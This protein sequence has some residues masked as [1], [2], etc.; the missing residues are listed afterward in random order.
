MNITC[1]PVSE[2]VRGVSGGS[3]DGGDGTERFLNKTRDDD[4]LIETFGSDAVRP[5]VIREFDGFD[6]ADDDIVDDDGDDDGDDDDDDDLLD[7]RLRTSKNLTQ[8]FDVF[9]SNRRESPSPPQSHPVLR[10]SF[11]SNLSVFGNESSRFARRNSSTAYTSKTDTIAVASTAAGIVTITGINPEAGT[12]TPTDINPAAGNITI[13]GINPATGTVIPTGINPAAG[14]VTPTGIV[15]F[16]I[17][18]AISAGRLRDISRQRLEDFTST[19]VN[20]EIRPS[21]ADIRHSPSSSATGEQEDSRSF[22]ISDDDKAEDNGTTSGRFT[23]TGDRSAATSDKLNYY[24]SSSSSKVSEELPEV[25]PEASPLRSSF[26][27]SAAGGDDEEGEHRRLLVERLGNFGKKGK[28]N[29]LEVLGTGGQGH[30]DANR[31]RDHVVVEPSSAV[32]TYV[33][34]RMTS[35]LNRIGGAEG[36]PPDSKRPIFEFS[37]RDGDDKQRGIDSVRMSRKSDH[38]KIGLPITVSASQN[39]GVEDAES[40]S[41]SLPPSVTGDRSAAQR[42]SAFDIRHDEH[43]ADIS[44][45]KSKQKPKVKLIRPKSDV[46]RFNDDPQSSPRITD[47]SGVVPDTRRAHVGRERGEATTSPSPS[48]EH[49]ASAA[50]AL[51]DLSA[52]R[53]VAPDT[54]AE[55]I[56][57]IYRKQL[58]STRTEGD[59]RETSNRLSSTSVLLPT[60]KAEVIR[61]RGGETVGRRETVLPPSSGSDGTSGFVGKIGY[62]ARTS[63]STDHHDGV[64]RKEGDGRGSLVVQPT[65]TWRTFDVIM[66]SYNPSAIASDDEPSTTSNSYEGHRD[67]QR[68]L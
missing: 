37:H 8:S 19:T 22:E 60:G 9:D 47:D 67:G 53:T 36:P 44:V 4:E 48:V 63:H 16:V 32:S 13:T 30:L 45:L 52:G 27:G 26:D 5:T 35:D 41:S 29:S 31:R 21:G 66:T 43:R 23:S 33:D 18:D 62:S 12:V 10:P 25:L 68:K 14:T 64:A 56:G 58:P 15:P 65:T 42:S 55:F 34:S 28:S 57:E 38:T 20:I 51:V 39:F 7:G 2:D 24:N 1:G 40:E 59:R 50:A 3:D 46:H 49:P 11:P 54:F 6:V 17:S 61:R